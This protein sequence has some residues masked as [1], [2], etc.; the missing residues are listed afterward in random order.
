VALKG[1][2][3]TN[4]TSARFVLFALVFVFV[5]ACKQDKSQTAAD[6]QDAD[7]VFLLESGD[8]PRALIRYQIAPGTK[9][10]SIMD[11]GFASLTM[12]ED[13]AELDVI[14]GVRLRFSAGPSVKTERGDRWDEH[15]VESEAVIPEGTPSRVARDLRAGVKVLNNVGGWIERDDRGIALATDLNERAKRPDVPARLLVMLVNART[16]LADVPLPAGPVGLGARWET[17]KQ[18][19]LYGF[20]VKQVN[21]YTLL[22]RVGN[23]IKLQVTTQQTALPQTISFPE[24]GLTIH[25][26]SYSSTASGEIVNNLHALSTEA[27]ARGESK[28]RL[29]VESADGTEKV[30]TERAFEFQMSN[31]EV[32]IP[33][34][35]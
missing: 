6:A 14:P 26:E 21:T 13:A 7:P 28:S 30:E 32:E 22:A 8:E 3:M 19:S 27:T 31:E 33:T 4:V 25:V 34:A 15:V 2:S 1:E 24:D 29:T 10:Q 5:A 18:L 17:R 23:E 11:F 20:K 12:T 16:T 35:P 9:T